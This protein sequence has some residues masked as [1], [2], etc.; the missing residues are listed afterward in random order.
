MNVAFWMISQVIASKLI[1]F[2]VSR[3]YFEATELAKINQV[4]KLLKV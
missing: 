1:D 4:E 2:F 3:K